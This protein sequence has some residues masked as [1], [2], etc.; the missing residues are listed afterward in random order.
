MLE[1][2]TVVESM[3]MAKAWALLAVYGFGGIGLLA[4]LSTALRRMMHF[5]ALADQAER[6]TK[7]NAPLAAG[8]CIVVGVVETAK[9]SEET[10]TVEVSQFGEE[11]E[12]SGSW[13]HSWT[14]R[15][16]KVRVAPFYLRRPSGERIRIEPTKEVFL[17]DDM[18]GYILVN[19]SERIR[20][21]K[22]VPG[23]EIIAKGVL[24]EDYDPESA[25]HAYRDLPKGW[26]M[27]AAQRGQPL[28][29]SSEPLAA[30]FQRMVRFHYRA[31]CWLFA[32]FLGVQVL[33]GSHHLRLIAGDADTAEV[34][35]R[36]TY[37]TTD[38]DDVDTT[39]YRVRVTLPWGPN[40][41]SD[42]SSDIY[43]ATKDGM[44]MP[45]NHVGQGR[46]QL[47]GRPS[48]HAFSFFLSAGILFLMFL[49]YRWRTKA[50]RPWYDRKL[51]DRSSGR[52]N[53]KTGLIRPQGMRLS[54]H[55]K[56]DYD[57][58]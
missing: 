55:E 24:R 50:K 14:E 36:Y 44:R 18:D 51:L 57:I 43:R 4:L 48:I 29:I 19:Q 2:D 45:I 34:E 49:F 10:V 3:H 30:R 12:N 15:D 22:L 58:E 53:P 6:A 13:S 11:S 16:R 40:Y 25:S 56:S 33:H 37:V 21:A 26:I 23:E 38:D 42:V 8:P 54:D 41:S 7:A 47:G 39:H 9:D 17:V 28:F 20:F 32:V 1:P 52:L 35:H 46:V 27:S 5:A 31:A